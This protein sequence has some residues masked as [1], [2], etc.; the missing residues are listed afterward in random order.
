[1]KSMIRAL[2]NLPTP[3]RAVFGVLLCTSVMG[4]I[5][6]AFP[7]M[8]VLGIVLC[9]LISAV[10]VVMCYLWILRALRR[11]KAAP[12]AKEIVNNTASAPAEVS[13]ATHRARLADLSDKFSEGITKIRA[14]GKNLYEMPWYLIVGEPGSGKTE[15]IRHSQIGFPRGFQ[16]ELQGAGGTLNMDWWFANDAVL[17]DTAGRLMFEDVKAGATSEWHAFLKLLRSYRRNCP[18]NGMIL[19]IPADSLI[20]DNE[21]K[22]AEKSEKIAH[23]LNEI[24]RIL[25]VRFPVFIMIT[26]CDLINGFKEYFDSLKD[27]QHQMIGW[28]NP[29]PLDQTVVP[30]LVDQHFSGIRDRMRRWRHRLLL[31]PIHREDPAAR[32]IDQVDALFEF[33]EAL[34]RLSAPLKKYIEAVFVPGNWS[35]NPLFLRGIYLTSS[36]REGEALDAILAE[37]LSVPTEALPDGRDWDRER[38]YFLKD[39]FLKKVFLECGL[40][41][42]AANTKQLLRRR[43]MILVAAG[44][45]AVS[46]L[47]LF[48]WFGRTEL[49]SSIGQHNRYWKLMADRFTGANPAQWSILGERDHRGSLLFYYRGNEELPGLHEPITLGRFPAASQQ[50]AADEIQIPWIFRVATSL[51]DMKDDR[52]AALGQMYNAVVLWPLTDAA[53]RTMR[54]DRHSTHWSPQATGALLYLVRVEAIAVSGSDRLKRDEEGALFNLLPVFQYVL[55]RESEDTARVSQDIPSLHKTLAW[56]DANRHNNRWPALSLEPLH[57]GSQAA[58]EIGTSKFLRYWADTAGTQGNRWTAVLSLSEGLSL[59]RDAERRILAVDDGLDTAVYPIIRTLDHPRLAQWQQAIKDIERAISLIDP[60]LKRLEPDLESKTLQTIYAEA[61]TEAIGYA[62][63]LFDELYTNMSLAASRGNEVYTSLSRQ[64]D[65]QREKI[66]E[67]L[68]KRGELARAELPNLASG[69]LNHPTNQADRNYRLRYQMYRLTDDQLMTVSRGVDLLGLSQA[70]HEVR[71]QVLQTT[72]MIDELSDRV[73]GDSIFIDAGRVCQFVLK[74]AAEIRTETLIRQAVAKTPDTDDQLIELARKHVGKESRISRPPLPMTLTE[75]REGD[76]FADEYHPDLAVK[77][78]D[79]RSLI[80]RFAT[81]TSDEKQ[82]DPVFSGQLRAA[83]NVLSEYERSY[84]RYWTQ[85]IRDRDTIPGR[86]KDLKW[87]KFKAM[88]REIDVY[89]VNK[90]LIDLTEDIHQALHSINVSTSLSDQRDQLIEALEREIKLL[91]SGEFDRV[92]DETIGQWMT[93]NSDEVAARSRLMAMPASEFASLFLTPYTENEADGGIPYWNG[94]YLNALRSL[95]NS[96]ETEAAAAL[97]ELKKNYGKYPLVQPQDH[98]GVL[99]TEQILQAYLLTQKIQILTSSDGP[100]D[101]IRT[102]GQ[103]G[104]TKYDKINVQLSRMT[105]STVLEKENGLWFRQVA[106]ILEAL[107]PTVKPLRCEVRILG[108]QE[109]REMPS[110]PEWGRMAIPMLRFLRVES[111]GTKHPLKNAD[112]NSKMLAAEFAVGLGDIALFFFEHSNGQPRGQLTFKGPWAPLRL[113]NSKG[114]IYDRKTN[115]YLVPLLNVTGIDQ[116]NDDG[117]KFYYWIEVSF[118]SP[119][120]DNIDWPKRETWP[121]R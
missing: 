44:F 81:H 111:N 31:D 105:G 85:T 99:T 9:G 48:T 16:D 75:T 103:G 119:L 53:R 92:C 13:A 76:Y 106:A 19:T 90:H 118:S 108:Q 49:R 37:A 20:A 78:L 23:Q 87:P 52:A 88:L 12:M 8:M 100:T 97:N 17:L 14:A 115:H 116:D 63:A 7:S 58:I 79:A 27:R 30:D 101:P 113:I 67:Q 94:M 36:M 54:S 2:I 34:M 77:L 3:L 95:A 41:T 82:D 73:P 62:E 65:N 39:M 114:A 89:Y 109:Q 29:D 35:P 18:I 60:A 5:Y 83:S 55:S 64:L 56:I 11:R 110:H 80:E 45:L 6:I 84:W 32:R 46:I 93:L 24:Q 38:A 4:L 10:A 47:A 1:M 112:P 86:E 102:I 28:S 117:K 42:K 96:A 68:S 104:L 91:H 21:D 61:E 72:S 69:L 22:L 57:D 98:Q 71:D 33:P 74:Q 15:A 43:S 70:D 59:F 25:G 120:P 51:S 40:V 50:R 26:K 66:K 107:S 121:I